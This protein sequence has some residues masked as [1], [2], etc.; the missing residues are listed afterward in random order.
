[1]TLGIKINE[2][3]KREY[4]LKGYWGDSTLEDY[5]N[6]SVKNSA[7]K[8]A[9]VDL[10]NTKYSYRELDLAANKLAAFFQTIGVKPGDFISMQ[11]PG[12]SEFT[13]IYIACLKVGAVVNP[14]LPNL[15]EKE[16]SYI[17]NK[18]E[19]KVLFIP[20]KF[21]KCEFYQKFQSLY[22]EIPS[23]KKV[24]VVEK[25]EAVFAGLTLQKILTKYKPIPINNGRQADDLAA[26]LFTSGTE[27][28]PKGVMLTHNNIISSEKAY[29]A[30]FNLTSYDT[31]LMPAPVAHATGFHHGVTASFLLGAT[32]VLQDIFKPEAC[33]ELI[34]REKC[35][36]GNLATAF[37]YDIVNLT[38]KKNHDITSLR[39]FLCGGSPV[40]RHLVQE[41]FDAGF[42][43]MGMYGSTES[44]PH[45]ASRIDDPSEKIISTDGKA[46]PGIEVKVVDNMRRE[47]PAGV[48]GEEASR[49]PNVF[50]GY[51]KEPELTNRVLDDDGWYYSGDLC[52]MGEDGY[53]R[54]NGR[55]KDII[56]RGG[57][58]ISS[59]EI[60]N[61]L[62]QHPNVKEVAVVG[63]PD[64]RLGE[65]S[66]AY[67]VLNQ[68]QDNLNLEAVS[69]FFSNMN[70]AKYKYP[71]RIEIIDK[72]PK[73][74]SCKIQK[75][76]LRED[77]KKKINGE[78]LVLV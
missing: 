74:G 69:A 5:W 63:M 4:R 25:E 71:E 76:I 43:V 24:V 34:E 78:L 42:K 6:S 67:V 70:V 66:C 3:Q 75:Y 28:V 10:Q 59:T 27:G 47:V 60:E 39:F 36:C 23:L 61:I 62:L 35:S 56:I 48:Q 37:V 31:I 38:K 65:R 44:V 26:V 51:L 57:E 2:W 15:R 20:A 19:S 17:L 13:L 58:N 54:I 1:M 29:A 7:E 22:Q 45:T 55:I 72:M 77:I 46:M 32:S 8:V 52:T 73:N 33:L 68:P 50:V 9:V 49:G 41:A 11:L 64:E 18:C 12:W 53:I 40:P 14:I 21:R 30:T 16:V